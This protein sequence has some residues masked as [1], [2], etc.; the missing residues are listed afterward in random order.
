M[1][2][3]KG[4]SKR[5]RFLI[6]ICI[7]L[8]IAFLIYIL[9]IKPL[10]DKQTNYTENLGEYE[11][12]YMDMSSATSGLQFD[13]DNLEK[14]KNEYLELRE[15]FNEP[16]SRDK[17]DDL[18]TGYVIGS[19]LKPLTLSIDNSEAVSVTNYRD[20]FISEDSVIDEGTT[21]EEA[22]YS[23]ITSTTVSLSCSGTRDNVYKLVNTL[24][25]AK[26]SIRVVNMSVSPMS[27]PPEY[28][29][30]IDAI[31]NAYGVSEDEAALAYEADA[32]IIIDDDEIAAELA[33]ITTRNARLNDNSNVTADLSIE[34]YTYDY[35]YI[36]YILNNQEADYNTEADEPDEYSDDDYF[37]SLMGDADSVGSD[38]ESSETDENEK[39][40]E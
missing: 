27:A 15:Y 37:A 18:F 1:N 35:D 8:V 39:A 34:L 3:K 38:A 13:K 16:M 5:D 31:I 32:K 23:Q 7:I 2:N 33:A 9:G 29:E 36:E 19:G 21:D 25:S 4:L 40:P 24:N 28:D 20:L 12:Q 26:D 30:I 11:M 6:Y 10:M 22:L 17:I 14:L